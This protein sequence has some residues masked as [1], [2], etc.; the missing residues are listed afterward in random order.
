MEWPIPCQEPVSQWLS[1]V[2]VCHICFGHK[3]GLWFSLQ[4]YFIFCHK[5]VILYS[6]LHVYNIS[7]AHCED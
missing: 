7:F 1:L 5:R 4:K 6:M 3:T 2:A